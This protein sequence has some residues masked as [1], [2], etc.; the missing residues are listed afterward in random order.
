MKKAIAILLLV[1]CAGLSAAAVSAE[2]EARFVTIREWLDAKG[3]C[4]DC[5][6]VVRI[7]A[8]LNPVWAEAEDETGMIHLFSGSGED[9]FII[10]FMDEENGVAE[11]E[12]F[13][14]ANPRYNEFEGTAEMADWTLLR[15]FPM[16][17][18]AE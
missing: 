13:V 17:A 18:A 7:K 4:G 2:G 9:S 6:L 5:M 8:V 14:I 1:I 11:G 3:E 10:N 15:R 12:I 16:P